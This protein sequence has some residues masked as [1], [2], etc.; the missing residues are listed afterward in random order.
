MLAQPRRERDLLIT[1][2]RPQ[3]WSVMLLAVLL[4]GSIG[5]QLVSPQILRSFIDTALAGGATQTLILIAL[6]F[7][8]AAL[9][10]QAVT[11]AATYLSEKVGWTATNALRS[12][13]ARHVLDLDLPFHQKHT[14]GELIE[15]IDGDV[16][17][18]S[19]F[20]SQ[21]VIQVFGSILLLLG[22]LLL[23]WREDWRVGLALTIFAL[24]ALVVLHRIRTIAVDAMTADREAHAG[25][26]G[27]IEERLAGLDDVRAN[28]G[29]GY[30]MRRLYHTMRDVAH[31]G[32]HAVMKSSTIWMSIMGL[33]ALGYALALSM[34]AYLFSRGAI[35]IGTVYLFFQ[36]TEMLRRPLEQISEQLR[37]FQKASASIGRVR[38]LY[39]IASAIKDGKGAA[40]LGG[41]LRIEF[42]HVTFAYDDD[43]PV[44]DNLSFRLERGK[45][46]G[47]LGRTGSGKTTLT[48]LVFRLYDVRAGAIRLGGV[49]IR[50]ATLRELR[51]HIGIVTQDVQLFETSVRDNLT[52]FDSS[53]P[54]ARLIEAIED[55]GLDSWFRALPD[56]L[57]TEL[58]AEHGLS[59]GEAQL[60]AFARVFLHDPGL[61][62]M[63]EASSR[64][65]P[66]TERL[67]ER[68]I[69]KLLRNR[70]AIIIAHRLGTV[71][72]ADEI[73]LLERGRLLEHGPRAELAADPDSRFHQLLRVGLEDV[74]V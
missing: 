73:M 18:L 16:T 24:L 58:T 6:L 11:V 52:L 38:E 70:T 37:E 43:A 48:R 34:G 62:I 19:T 42:D 65:D 39:G 36:Y 30:V 53:I 66:A 14:A 5:L 57:D 50:D 41:P 56:G 61:V 45:V 49:D 10:T 3:R 7:L 46:L 2:L 31:K 25:L 4:L 51:G 21:L 72:R 44:L 27:L 64:L 59:A 9:G 71:Q 1:Y 15:R 54:D 55:L 47:L 74:L 40:I 17:T 60:L 29:G 23:L 20:F 69:D 67:I 12:H 33:F 22:V 28:G 35:T 32:H 63:D 8:G 26:F 13:L 68:A